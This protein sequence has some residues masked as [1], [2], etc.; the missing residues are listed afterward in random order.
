MSAAAVLLIFASVALHVTW[1]AISKSVRPTPAFFLLASVVSSI[2]LLPVVFWHHDIALPTLRLVLPA[3][4]PTG[5][6][7]AF[8]NVALAR[9]YRGGDLSLVYPLARSLGPVCVALVSVAIGRGESIGLGCATGIALIALGS[10]V[11]PLRHFDAFRLDRYR[12]PPF[13]WAVVTAAATAGY[14]LLDDQALRWLRAESAIPLDTAEQSLLYA[15]MQAWA[16]TLALGLY[17]IGA[18]RE[19]AEISEAFRTLRRQA[20]VVGIFGYASYILILA[21]MAFVDDVTY[22]AAFRQLGIPLAIFVGM[23]LLREPLSAPRVVGGALCTVG[24]LLIAA[25]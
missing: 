12:T 5:V 23:A 11:L 18:R 9:A 7:A 25:G 24:L 2:T 21:A 15:A 22:V 17:V 3:L 10:A 8:Y 13:V 1:N 16:T 19:R 20:L 14:T 6:F 4:V